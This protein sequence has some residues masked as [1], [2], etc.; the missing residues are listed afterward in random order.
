[1]WTGYSFFTLE[2]YGVAQKTLSFRL[3]LPAAS[4]GG[5]KLDVWPGKSL[6][7]TITNL[8]EGK[9]SANT[10]HSRY[11]VHCG[12]I[13]DVKRSQESRKQERAT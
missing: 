6:F 9:L 11:N 2:R 7:S 5:L 3:K 10:V 13:S 1:M 8:A 12:K 4:T